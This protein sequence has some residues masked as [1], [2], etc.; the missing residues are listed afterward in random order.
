[1]TISGSLRRGFALAGIVI[2][3]LLLA[4]PLRSAVYE[5]VIIPAAYVWWVVSLAYHSVQQS[6]WWI[7]A[8]VIVLVFLARSLRPAGSLR[9]RIRLK[10]RP[11]VGQVEALS[12]WV[13]RME[14]GIYF[15]WLIANRL[16]KI[17]HEILAQRMGGISRSFF[18]PLTGPEWMPDPSVQIYLE[19]GLK[20]SF[21]DY[22]LRRRLFS[23]PAQTPLDH[24]VTEV[25]RYL[26]SQLGDQ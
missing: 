6:V 19:S 20:G 22:P 15:K 1:M 21:A 10:R 17:A 23:K 14:R 3:A 7:V 13:R 25:I 9:K 24:D 11:V 5:L 16:G 8:L 26:E 4:F 12:A 2:I 18:D